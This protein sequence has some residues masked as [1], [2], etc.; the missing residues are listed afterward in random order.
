M[1]PKTDEPQTE[2]SPF[3]SVGRK[4]TVQAKIATMLLAEMNKKNIEAVI[5]RA[6]E[7]YGPGKTQ[8]LTNSLIFDNIKQG[9]K[10]KV[11]LKDNVLR[12]LI[13]TPDAS[14]V[15]ALIGNTT[16]TYSQTWHLP[17]DDHRLTYKG[18]I[19][20]ASRVSKKKFKYSILPTSVFKLGGLFNKQLKE[21][22]ELLPRY[23]HDNIFLSTKFKQ[24]F[25][26]FE[27]TTYQE[28]ITRL[29]SE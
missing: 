27:I 6:P 10:L 19:D 5:C 21:V 16:D 22:Q 25:P 8:S 7:F 4:S 17:C 3:V 28:G 11:L 29:L 12:T 26:N 23:T 18:L 13:W 14:R 1:Y 9:K 15:M 24:R 20:L 2:N